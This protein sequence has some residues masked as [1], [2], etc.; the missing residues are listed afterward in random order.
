MCNRAAHTG[1]HVQNRWHTH[2]SYAAFR[3][4]S[5]ENPGHQ[6]EGPS[7]TLRVKSSLVKFR[8]V[9]PT[10]TVRKITHRRVRRTARLYHGA[11]SSPDDCAGKGSPLASPM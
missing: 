10:L 8:Q 2:S 4:V 9:Q 1:I 7:F 6:G 3:Y 11:G 5:R